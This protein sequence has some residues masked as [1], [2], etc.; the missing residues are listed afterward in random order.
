[1]SDVQANNESSFR[2]A[3]LLEYHR[4]KF[5]LYRIMGP[6]LGRRIQ[7][8]RLETVKSIHDQA[9]SWERQLPDSLRLE[10]YEDDDTLEQQRLLAMQTLALQLT[11]DNLLIILHRSVAFGDG[12]IKVDSGSGASRLEQVS[13][14]RRQLLQSALRTSELHK[15]HRLLQACRETHAVMHI[16]ICLFT[17][18]VVLCAIAL[19]DPLSS[20]SEKAKVG[21]MNILRMHQDSVSNRHLLSIQSVKI[22]K[23]L[24]T[25]VMQA[26]QKI[27]IGPPSPASVS[28]PERPTSRESTT[29][30]PSQNS[31]MASTQSRNNNDRNAARASAHRGFLNPLQEGMSACSQLTG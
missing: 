9:V 11:Y 16:G 4:W 22:L 23:D 24:V 12:G 21:I 14:S 8:N 18:G 10:T 31:P 28:H 2:Q 19:S 29:F 3:P 20:T 17:S 27:I 25:V 15:Y 30:L 6:F 1:M 7:T 13:F 26:E 5:K